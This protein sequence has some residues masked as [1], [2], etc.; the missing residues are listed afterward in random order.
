MQDFISVLRDS[1]FVQ[2]REAVQN[3]FKLSVA[4]TLH[5]PAQKV[6]NWNKIT[7]RLVRARHRQAGFDIDR[8]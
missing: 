7:R 3:K 8:A 6:P 1:N 2:T 5:P 4:T